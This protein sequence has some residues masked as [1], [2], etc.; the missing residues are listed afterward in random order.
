VVTVKGEYE[1]DQT[2]T[3]LRRLVRKGTLRLRPVLRQ[4]ARL[5]RNGRAVFDFN[6]PRTDDFYIGRLTLGNVADPPGNRREDV[7]RDLCPGEPLGEAEHSDRFTL[8][9]VAVPVTEVPDR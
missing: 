5:D 2:R 8:G 7:P 1:R 4:R 6:S 9:M 3:S